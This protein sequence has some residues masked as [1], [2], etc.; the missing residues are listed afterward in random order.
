MNNEV[1]NDAVHNILWNEL[2]EKILAEQIY[3]HFPNSVNTVLDVG[4]GD[5]YLSYYLQKKKPSLMYYGIDK[6]IIRLKRISQKVPFVKKALADITC[7][8]LKSNSIDLVICSEVLEHI[9]NYHKALTEL[10][11]VTKKYLIIT[12][13]N[14]QEL[15]QIICP[16]CQK[17][18]YL[19]GHLHKFTKQSINT[20]LN[21]FSSAKI[22]LISTF[23][24][25][26]TYNKLTLKFPSFLRYHLDKIITSLAKIV[27]FFKGNYL[28]I[29][30]EKHE[31]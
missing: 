18:H 27:P 29:I 14:N 7:I 30:L 20:D 23:Y 15:T 17:K 19:S 2:R 1:E 16:H 3:Y 22:T 8:P 12:I 9:S 4:C 25:I 28:I 5:G 13:P 24:T 26:Y 11:R 10:L 31:R 6:S 21:Q